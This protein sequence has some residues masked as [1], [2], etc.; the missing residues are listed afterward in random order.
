MSEDIRVN[1]SFEPIAATIA[2]LLTTKGIVETKG[3]AVALN[4]QVVPP[5]AWATTK[6]VAG[7][8]VEIVRAV[9]G[10]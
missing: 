3:L 2:A 5:G 9:G 10:G 4:D 1:G 6:L 8:A 7:D